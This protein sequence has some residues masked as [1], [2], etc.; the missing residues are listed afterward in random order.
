MASIANKKKLNIIPLNNIPDI[1]INFTTVKINENGLCNNLKKSHSNKVLF[2][3]SYENNSPSNGNDITIDNNECNKK[4]KND[5]KEDKGIINNIIENDTILVNNKIEPKINKPLSLFSIQYNNSLNKYVL[6]SLV[7]EIFFALKISSNK[8]FYLDDSKRYYLQ[9]TDT[10]ISI[11][12]NNID[13]NIIIKI[14]NINKEKNDK[15]KYIFEYNQLPIT[16]GRIGCNINIHKNYIS[17]IH[18]IINYD[19]NIN[20]FFIKD[21]DS[22]NGSLI[23]LKKGKEI[24]LE[25][26]NF[27][28][29]VKEDF[30]LM[31]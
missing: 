5:N 24:K 23:L 14:L 29:L 1:F 22:T 11:L 9:L 10:I 27:F 18:L 16:I 7:E 28:F 20:Q 8:N 26:K 4:E 25:D 31:R 30:I 21:N 19:T 15:S 3:L 13:K 2:N 6:S 12:P 17:K